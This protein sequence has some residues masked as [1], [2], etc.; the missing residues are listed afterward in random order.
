MED[1]ARLKI[2]VV[3]GAS[4]SCLCGWLGDSLKIRVSAPPERGKAN[5]A[6]IKL[7]AKELQLNESALSVIS[8]RASQHKVV[9]IR[10]EKTSEVLRK[11]GAKRA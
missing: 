1:V 10:G 5:E 4:Q 3:P 11:L 6:V 9:E 8:G 7:L 2:K